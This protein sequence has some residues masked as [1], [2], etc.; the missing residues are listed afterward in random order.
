MQEIDLWKNSKTEKEYKV[1]YS[2]VDSFFENLYDYDYNHTININGI[3]FSGLKYRE[4]QNSYALDS[5]GAIQNNEILLI[6]AGVGIGK[7]YGYLIPIFYTY[8]NV[9][10]FKKVVISTSS[11][12]LQEQLVGDIKKISKML[13]IKLKVDIAKGINNYACL[14]KIYQQINSRSTDK[15]TK[16][17]L[18][19]LANQMEKIKSSDKLDLIPISE[20]I[21]KTIQLQSRGYCSNCSYSKTCPFIK[22][23]AVLSKN[24]III[25]NHA[26]LIRNI[27]DGTEL[28]ARDINMMMID[29]AHKMYENIQNIRTQEIKLED[30]KDQIEKIGWEITHKY[31]D[32]IFI[33]N[34]SEKY[35]LETFI[36]QLK[37]DITILFS[38]IRESASKNFY[39]LQRNTSNREDYSIMDANRLS[40]RVTKTVFDNLHKVLKELKLFI[41]E[42]NAY[43][44]KYR[45]KIKTKEIEKIKTIYM[46][47]FDIAKQSKSK[48]IY[49]VDFY[50]DN[51][52]TLNYVP[53]DNSDIIKDIFSRD[54]PMIWT[55]GTMLD[56][57]NTYNYFCEDLGLYQIGE[58][59]QRTITDGD[60]QIS[61]YDYD[62]NALFY[63]NP[64][65]AKPN[66]KD[67][68]KDLVVEIDELI[69]ATE[70]KALILFTSKKTMNKVYELL[71]RDK[72]PFKI[73]LHKDN[74]T[75]KIKEHFAK[76]VNSCLFATGAFWEGIDIKGSS[77]SN[78]IITHLPFDQVD[79]INQ[80]K[81]SIYP[82]K[83]QFRKVYF[84]NMLIKF[85]QAVG[86]LI[87]SD[88]DTG[89]V[90]CL[91]SRFDKY[92]AEMT[93]S[94]PI[95]NYTTN[96]KELYQ[97]IDN[98]ILTSNKKIV[99]K[100]VS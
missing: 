73:L 49:W 26:N 31:H 4:G 41:N 24:N 81:A 51:K 67:Y 53:K 71:N 29:E 33:F 19:D 79:A 90:C 72:Y 70:G 95:T 32:T 76:D 75:N 3:D 46:I 38:S 92:K 61:P 78:L 42:I 11:I 69:R 66:D 99:K 85:R 23:Q 56:S 58:L 39:A 37:L 1:A 64:S 5:M 35:D 82:S 97:F 8:D 21:W 13:G 59:T 16:K 84:P 27:L 9:K 20:Q 12:A 2:K 28:A 25:T 48:N 15:K 83:D 89:I 65:L 100:K 22:R 54:I 93:S 87:R 60:E 63:H 98:K 30:I 68:I 45:I 36:T 18:N 14:S 44:Y 7:S 17:I 94:I 55:S 57:K 34:Q 62:N 80:Y 86:R 91:D 74:N 50:E 40:F 77:L 43:E 96:K 88:T 10:Q 47:L 52:I 6:Q